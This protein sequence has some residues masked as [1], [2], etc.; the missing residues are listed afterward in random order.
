MTDPSSRPGPNGIAGFARHGRLRTSGPAAAILRFLAAAIAVILVSALC[1]VAITANQLVSSEKTINIHPGEAVA[2]P[3]SIGAYPGGFN[4][5]IVGSDTRAGQGGI[6]AGAGSGGALNDVTMLLHVSGDHTSATAVSIPRD[7]VVPMPAC[8]LGGPATGLPINNTL[9]YGG[10][11]CVV[12]TVEDL[13][14]LKIQFA[15]MIT[16]RG[17][18][19]M[20][21]A[22]GGVPVC[23]K[24]NLND[25]EVGLHLTSGTHVLKGYTALKF[26]RS[27]HGVG[28]GSDLGRISSQQVYLSSLVRTLKS[29]GTLSNLGTLYKI[30][31][32]A[33]RNMQ[34]S[35]S[36]KPLDTQIAIAQALKNI[37]LDKVTF[38]QYP[39][40]LGGTGIFAGKVQPETAKADALFALIKADKPFTLGTTA[41]SIGSVPDKSKPSTTPTP[42]ASST[43]S[44]SNTVLNGYL[45]QTAGQYTCS[46]AN[47]Q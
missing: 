28:D 43:D 27:R 22:V 13:T 24:G 19:E 37:Q 41:T 44:P 35:T 3:P 10:L 32:A 12:S 21:N 2:P 31:S 40:T 16:F 23:V 42:S 39:G 30:A 26:L 17:V 33:T 46:K 5:L 11:P 45:G 8:P 1:V 29:S 15:G 36:L 14:G 9:S 7:M 38:L 47:S 4:I 25:S 18:I 34:L 6:G 20:S